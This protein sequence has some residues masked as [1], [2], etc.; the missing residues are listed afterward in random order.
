MIFDAISN[1]FLT[2][3]SST[4]KSFLLQKPYAMRSN[5]GLCLTIDEYIPS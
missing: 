4:D 5:G 3:K 1:T 2:M